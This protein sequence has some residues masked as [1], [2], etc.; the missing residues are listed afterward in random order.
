MNAYNK[1]LVGTLRRDAARAPQLC[2]Y[3]SPVIT[4]RTLVH[5]PND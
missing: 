4:P 3:A 2:R 5:A 1:S